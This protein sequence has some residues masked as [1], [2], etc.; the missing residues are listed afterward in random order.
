VQ[1]KS[2][3]QATQDLQDR[4]TDNFHES[5][6]HMLLHRATVTNATVDI[7]DEKMR[8][9]VTSELITGQIIALLS[10]MRDLRLLDGAQYDEFTTYLLHSLVSQHGEFI[11]W[12]NPK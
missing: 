6:N 4:L 12:H 8:A 7:Q 3:L 1:D 10:L 2:F 11:T 9:I 5:I